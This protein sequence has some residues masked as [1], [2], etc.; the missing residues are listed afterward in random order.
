MI[1]S[2]TGL[3]CLLGFALSQGLRDAFFGNVFQSVSF[4]IVA[5]LAFGLATLVFGLL[6][7]VR[8]PA[9]F[10]MLV[11]HPVTFVALNVTTAIA[12][13]SFFFGLKHLEPAV[14]ATLYNGSGPIAVLLFGALQWTTAA[15]RVRS[16]TVCYV[17]IALA[18]AALA[19]VVLSGRSGLPV[20][21]P[22]VVAIALLTVVGGG[23]TIA[24]SHLIA[25]QLNDLGVGSN[26][27]MGTR[28]I[29][30][31]WAA[32]VIGT[33]MGD[34]S[35]PAEPEALPV[36]AGT[37]F[38]LIAIPSF[39]LQLGIARASPLTVNVMRA[40]GP[41]CVFAIQQFDGRLAFSTATFLCVLAFSGFATLASFL[42]A[43]AEIRQCQSAPVA[44]SITAIR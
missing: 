27:L 18:L 10:R 43:Y 30:A 25:R 33:M 31:F 42:R 20:S 22:I 6:T 38:G 14:A 44:P 4:F 9:D 24:A 15:E 29:A 11:A 7:L 39:L 2:V 12:W 26:A 28:F 3:L 32:L 41:V 1:S 8:R 37:A 17:G 23:I 19:Y 21:N 34:L 13:L 36:L 35:K 40:L 5:A 16:E